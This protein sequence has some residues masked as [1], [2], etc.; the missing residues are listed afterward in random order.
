MQGSWQPVLVCFRRWLSSVLPLLKTHAFRRAAQSCGRQEPVIT[1]APSDPD[2]QLDSRQ[3]DIA[4]SQLSKA[5][6]PI[7]E[8]ADDEKPTDITESAPAPEA[9]RQR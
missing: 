8:M 7:E 5:Q 6:D 4:S 9:P 2:A 3:A 1:P